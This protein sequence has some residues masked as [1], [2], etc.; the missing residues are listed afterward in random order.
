[1]KYRG[2]APFLFVD[3][4]DAQLNELEDG[5][6]APFMSFV[7]YIGYADEMKYGELPQ[8]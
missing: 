6:N 1:M 3:F 4:E 5:G 8:I 2:I 7:G